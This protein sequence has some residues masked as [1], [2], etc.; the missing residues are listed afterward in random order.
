MRHGWLSAIRPGSSPSRSGQ[1]TIARARRTGRPRRLSRRATVSSSARLTA[2]VESLLGHPRLLSL[3][4]LGGRDSRPRRIGPAW[5]ADP[6]RACSRAARS[7]G[8]LDADCRRP[9]RLRAAL[10]GICARLAHARRLAAARRSCSPRSRMP[11]GSPRREIRRSTGGF[12]STSP[13]ASPRG[14]RRPS[15]APSGET[16]RIVAIGTSVV[17]ALESAAD[18]DGEVRA[19]DGVARGRI[20]RGTTAPRRRCDPDRRA[21]ARR[22]PFRAPA[23]LRRRCGAER[24][25]RGPRRARLP[26]P[27]VR[28]FRADRTPALPSWQS[29]PD[30]A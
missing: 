14:A 28:R 23:G 11:P 10:G 18:A 30:E 22:K 13:T 26:H 27:R 8:R 25:L 29:R 5:A 19:G 20:G 12:P 4:F 7:L 9:D 21:S 16:A 3:R 15:R 24:H 1:A 2:E 6:I 17:R